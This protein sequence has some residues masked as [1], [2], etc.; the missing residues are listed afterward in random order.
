[1]QLE[2]IK[3]EKDERFQLPKIHA[4]PHLSKSAVPTRE[5]KG[6]QVTDWVM[7]SKFLS[8]EL[9]RHHLIMAYIRAWVN[10]GHKCIV[11]TEFVEQSEKLLE[12]MK[13]LPAAFIRLSIKP[14]VTDILAKILIMTHATYNGSSFS[15]EYRVLLTFPCRVVNYQL[16]IDLH[17]IYDSNIEVV[18][19]KW[20]Q[21]F[22]LEEL[23]KD[24]QVHVWAEAQRQLIGI[25][26]SIARIHRSIHRIHA[27]DKPT[28]DT[29]ATIRR[30]PFLHRKEKQISA[31]LTAEQI[32]QVEDYMK[33][34]KRPKMIIKNERKSEL[35]E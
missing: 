34:A 35:V 17:C 5:R 13:H 12:V 25:K 29:N 10:L 22:K 3:E 27:L 14:S 23:V 9:T 26:N 16:P 4:I 19:R 24:Q 15:P 8:L 28:D 2:D 11:V 21:Y 31:K 18:C 20:N 32:K 7:L 6:C 1:M 30:L 33:P